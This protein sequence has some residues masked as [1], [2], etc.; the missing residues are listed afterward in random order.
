MINIYDS[1][2]QD[3]V[4]QIE[5]LQNFQLQPLFEALYTCLE[6][7]RQVFII[8]NGGSGGNA[9]HIANDFLYPISKKMGIG[10]KAHSL[11]E[12]PSTICC[13]ANDEGYE[14]IFSA[15]LKVLGQSGD[16]LIALSGSGNSPNIVNCLNIAKEMSI[17]SFSMLGYDGGKCLGISDHVIHFDTSDMQVCEDMQMVVANCALKE[18]YHRINAG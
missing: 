15:Q 4:R 2:T 17:K 18:I 7:R 8:G 11:V 13:L 10:I 12:N 5:K 14:H 9:N 3:L 1:Y 6:E 16:I